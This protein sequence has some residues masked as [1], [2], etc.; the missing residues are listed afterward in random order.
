LFTGTGSPAIVTVTS[1]AWAPTPSSATSSGTG[2]VPT[3]MG[4]VRVAATF[5][6]ARI[7]TVAG[8]AR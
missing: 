8:P 7:S 3:M 4:S 6:S 5:P 1:I 2:V